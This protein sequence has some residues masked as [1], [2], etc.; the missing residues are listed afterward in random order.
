MNQNN[1][2]TSLICP[3]LTNQSDIVRLGHGSGGTMSS[4]LLSNLF[5]PALGNEILNQLDDASIIQVRDT[6]LA[7]TIDSYV[8]NPIFFR[9]VI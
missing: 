9:V 6:Q 1:T 8:V 7:M 5:L 4:Q 2:I 3:T